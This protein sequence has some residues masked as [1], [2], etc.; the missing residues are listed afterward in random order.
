MLPGVLFL[1]DYIWHIWHIFCIGP[2]LACVFLFFESGG[3][4]YK[5]ELM[6]DC[7]HLLFDIQLDTIY[8][9]LLKW[10]G[11]LRNELICAITLSCFSSVFV[12]DCVVLGYLVCWNLVLYVK[13]CSKQTS[14][15]LVMLK[16]GICTDLYF[17]IVVFVKEVHRCLF[18][19]WVFSVFCHSFCRIFCWSH[20][21]NVL[22]AFIVWTNTPIL[23]IQQFY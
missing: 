15:L 12:L 18:P 13:G 3:Y 14:L 6:Q 19:S 4:L 10:W 2:S 1:L 16:K 7:Q 22:S 21:K 20:G 23:S 8:A 5:L 11:T 9:F 17:F